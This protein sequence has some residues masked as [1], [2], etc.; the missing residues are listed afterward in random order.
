M[1]IYSYRSQTQ[2]KEHA[3]CKMSEERNVFFI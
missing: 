3:K 1:H 2:W